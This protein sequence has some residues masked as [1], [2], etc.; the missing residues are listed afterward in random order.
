MAE[1][2]ISPPAPPEY[3]AAL[4]DL[5]PLT[6]QILYARGLTDAEAAYRFMSSTP[7]PVDPFAFADMER[8]VAR[9]LAAVG[10]DEPIAVYA[11]YDCDGVT[12]GA[13]LVRTLISLGARAQIYIPDRFEEGYGLNV[14][15]LD[16]LKAQGVGL[17]ITVD[18]GVRAHREAQHARS[19]GLDLIVTDH[20]ELEAD[21]LPDAFAVIDPKRPDCPYQFAHLAGVGVAFRLAQCLLRTARA[22]GLPINSVTEASLLDL[23]ALG[24]VADVVPLVGENRALVR[25]GLE[26]L[27]CAPR[28]GLQHLIQ[29]AGLRVG[30][31]DAMRVAFALAPR[32]NAA[33]RLENARAAYDLLMCED[34][35]QAAALAAQLDRQNS[36]RQQVMAAI[37]ADAEQRAIAQHPADE[38]DLPAVLFA[39]SPDYNIGVVGLAAARLA[40]KFHRPAVVVGICGDEA[41]GSCRSVAGF[42]I[43]AALDR[44]SDLLIKHGGHAAAAGFTARADALDALQARLRAIAELEQPEGG[45]Q[46]VLQ[47]DAEVALD[48]IDARAIADLQRL[49]PH[50]QGNPPPTLVV[51]AATVAAVR[52]VGRANGQGDQ[53][54]LQLRLTDARRTTWDAIAWRMGERAGEIAEGATISLVCRLSAG[55]RNGQPRLELEVL[56]F[57]TSA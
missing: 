14:Q 11:D 2:K 15:A 18:C 46:R 38:G 53:P 33:G 24:T 17:V 55:A 4:R 20:H 10:R 40:E 16:K 25:A 50:G 52:R 28:L 37:A 57:R 32:L 23:V 6:A 47:A 35:A 12:A 7:D 48:Q 19:L 27:N 45:W 36:E 54:H 29:V 3:L 43:I 21:S 41:R 8:A 56:D 9:I 44:C 39:A 30:A 42:D 31:L 26:R 13:L 34:P 22:A 49:E 5:H 1:W 51:R